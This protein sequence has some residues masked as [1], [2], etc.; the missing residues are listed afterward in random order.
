MKV[1]VLALYF[2]E[3][4]VG[5]LWPSYKRRSMQYEYVIIF[6]VEVVCF[7]II[8]DSL[9]YLSRPEFALYENDVD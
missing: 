4:E 5:Y 9:K 6:P 7:A 2:D 1:C 3:N 8:Y